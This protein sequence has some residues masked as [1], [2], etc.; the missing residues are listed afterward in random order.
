MPSQLKDMFGEEMPVPFAVSVRVRV[1]SCM[2]VCCKNVKFGI[3]KM[4]ICS[5]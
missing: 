5:L 2:C 3:K 4:I 1:R